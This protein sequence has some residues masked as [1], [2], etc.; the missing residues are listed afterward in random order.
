MKFFSG[1]S[2]VRLQQSK[3]N[4]SWHTFFVWFLSKELCALF[5]TF[6]IHSNRLKQAQRPFCVVV[7]VFF[8]WF[9]KKIQF[10]NN[11]LCACVFSGFLQAPILDFE[12]II[13]YTSNLKIIRSPS[14]KAESGVSY[15]HGRGEGREVSPGRGPRSK[16]RHRTKSV[17]KEERCPAPE[18][19]V[20]TFSIHFILVSV[21][22]TFLPPHQPAVPYHMTAIS[23][24]LLLM[25]PDG[26]A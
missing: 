24:N 11:M 25:L 14:K 10:I 17:R 19:E 23:Y 6:S 18:E 22:L 5:I 15:H 26:E 12:K 20:I 4:S 9:L 21:L 3:S 2:V 16:G 7:G 13:I 8:F 1:G